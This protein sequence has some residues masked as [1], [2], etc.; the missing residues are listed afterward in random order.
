MTPRPANRRRPAKRRNSKSKRAGDGG[1]KAEEQRATS[2]SIEATEAEVGPEVEAFLWN[3]RL[4]TP[5][6]LAALLGTC[7]SSRSLAAKTSSKEGKP[8]G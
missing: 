4:E 3:E 6:C 2:L 1:S 8:S 7:G 5:C